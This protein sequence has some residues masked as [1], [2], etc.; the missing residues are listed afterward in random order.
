MNIYCQFN[1]HFKDV[2]VCKLTCPRE[3]KCPEFQKLYDEKGREIRWLLFKYMEK[4]P[5]KEYK[6]MLIP[7]KGRKPTM[8]QYICIREG[9]IELL[10]EEELVEKTKNGEFFQSYFEVGREM[11]I[12]IKLVPKKKPGADKK[13]AVKKA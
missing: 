5:D 7:K 1:H 2:L 3:F 6:I 13:K 10:K 12:S 9:N 11:E 8:K 4:Y